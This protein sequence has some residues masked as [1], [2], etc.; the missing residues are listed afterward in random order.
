[1][2]DKCV[3]KIPDKVKKLCCICKSFVHCLW[4]RGRVF[5]EIWLE[6]A[7]NKSRFSLPN[8]RKQVEERKLKNM[9]TK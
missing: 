7:I 9:R 1:M 6:Y 3:E 4:Y 5:L 2:Q 8:Q